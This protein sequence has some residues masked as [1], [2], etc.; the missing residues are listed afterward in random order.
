MTEGVIF[1]LQ[2]KKFF[3]Y[4]G[5]CFPSSCPKR[6]YDGRVRK[7]C[8][9]WPG[10]VLEGHFRAS[11]KKGGCCCSRCRVKAGNRMKNAV[12][13][14]FCVLKAIY[15]MLCFAPLKKGVGVRSRGFRPSRGGFSCVGDRFFVHQKRENSNQKCP[16]WRFL[17]GKKAKTQ[18]F[19]CPMLFFASIDY[20]C[21]TGIFFVFLYFC[22]FD[23]QRLYTKSCPR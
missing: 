14:R 10:M 16:K 20:Q 17:G 3:P 19:S 13:C 18:R 4:D 12:L 11:Q 23:L 2:R 15:F 1:S 21:I 9:L 6:G 7:I 22:D 8:V 5:V